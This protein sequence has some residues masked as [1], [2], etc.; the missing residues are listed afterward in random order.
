MAV[1]NIKIKSM[2]KATVGIT[3]PE[4]SL[5]RTW[6]RKGAIQL[7]P[8]ELLEQAFYLPGVEYMF[9]TGILYIEDRAARITLGLETDSSSGLEEKVEMIV[10]TDEYTQKLLTSIPL[11]EFRETLDKLSG[12][13]LNELATSA[14]DFRITDYQRCLLLKERTGRDVLK[15]VM[16]ANEEDTVDNATN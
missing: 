15:I 16:R 2:A 13:Q 12:P 3:V 11:K 9:K 4:L 1:D 14:I 7:I 6:A 10:L 8:M 5:R